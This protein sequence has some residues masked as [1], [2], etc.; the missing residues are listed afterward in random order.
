MPVFKEMKKRRRT[1]PL[2][3]KE[4]PRQLPGRTSN[5]CPPGSVCGGGRGETLQRMPICPGT[6]L[7]RD[8]W[9]LLVH[10]LWSLPSRRSRFACSLKAT[11]SFFPV[12]L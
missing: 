11:C 10:G 2:S 1:G 7:F 6:K 3:G 8:S 4:L 9:H 5:A 12:A